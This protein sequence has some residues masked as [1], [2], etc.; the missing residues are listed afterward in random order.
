MLTYL[1]G[2]LIGWIPNNEAA[3]DSKIQKQP[4]FYDSGVIKAADA[5]YCGSVGCFLSPGS[6]DGAVSGIFSGAFVSKS[7]DE[8]F[9]FL[10]ESVPKARIPE[11]ESSVALPCDAGLAAPSVVPGASLE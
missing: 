4:F 9:R 11:S 8:F 1:D 10:R 3:Y 2:F 5:N 7:R 6:N